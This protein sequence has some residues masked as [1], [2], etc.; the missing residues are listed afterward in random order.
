MK[1]LTHSLENDTKTCT[2]QFKIIVLHDSKKE[3][4]APLGTLLRHRHVLHPTF[5][6]IFVVV[7]CT[8]LG[9]FGHFYVSPC[10]LK[11]V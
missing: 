5:S 4:K 7:S 9:I 3:L 1:E 10:V 11:F 8:F 6:E 2:S